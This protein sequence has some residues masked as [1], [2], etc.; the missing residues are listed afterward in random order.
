[1]RDIA[2][3]SYIF[4][5][6]FLIFSAKSLTI[7]VYRDLFK[8][9]NLKFQKFLKKQTEN[10]Q[11]LIHKLQFFKFKDTIKKNTRCNRPVEQNDYVDANYIYFK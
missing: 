8:P 9:T 11:K 10:I 5:N 4:Y 1:M 2:Y 3:R 6:V 7:Y